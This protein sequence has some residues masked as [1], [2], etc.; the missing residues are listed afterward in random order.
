MNTL[1]ALWMWRDGLSCRVTQ[2]YN[3]VRT[4]QHVKLHTKM[5]QETVSSSLD[6]SSC[7]ISQGGQVNLVL[8]IVCIITE[9]ILPEIFLKTEFLSINHYFDNIVFYSHF[10]D[11]WRNVIKS[12]F[13]IQLRW[14]QSE[15]LHLSNNVQNVIVWLNPSLFS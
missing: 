4:T 11:K 12:S 7:R 1:S 15:T 3:Q 5:Q 8:Y 2:P 14:S 10:Y 6:A 9:L 13:Q